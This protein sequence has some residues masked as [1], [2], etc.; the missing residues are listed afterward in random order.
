MHSS[1]FG[2]AKLRHK[3]V[4]ARRENGWL[5]L[6][7]TACDRPGTHFFVAVSAPRTFE[8]VGYGFRRHRVR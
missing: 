6:P 5:T 1:L 7:P 4:S 3:K 2:P 8:S